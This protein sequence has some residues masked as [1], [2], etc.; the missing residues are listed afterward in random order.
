MAG[1]LDEHISDIYIYIYIFDCQIYKKGL[2][3]RI[4]DIL[5]LMPCN[6]SNSCQNIFNVPKNLFGLTH[7]FALQYIVSTSF[8]KWSCFFFHRGS[9]TSLFGLPKGWNTLHDLCPDFP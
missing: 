7:H 2:K 4:L 3:Y 8:Q 6:F 5:Y 9:K 1:G